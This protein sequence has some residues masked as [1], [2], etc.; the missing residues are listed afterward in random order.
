VLFFSSVN[1]KSFDLDNFV[2][3]WAVDLNPTTEDI[4][5]YRFF[6]QRSNSPEGP[7]DELNTPAPLT[8]VYTFTD[9]QIDRLSKWRRYFYRIR[10][11]DVTDPTV[12][13]ISSPK[14]FLVPIL[15]IQS[16]V[17][18]EIIR[19]EKIILNGIG[20]TP[21]TVGIKCLVFIRRTFG[22]RCPDCWDPVKKKVSRSQCEQCFA[23][24]FKGGYHAPIVV[25][26]NFS[27]PA[28]QV[29]LTPIGETQPDVIKA[30]MTN[31]PPLT[32]GDLI[33]DSNNVRWRVVNQTRTEALRNM[34]RQTLS[35]YHLPPGDIEYLVPFDT[36]L[37]L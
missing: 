7:F 10:A 32:G 35:L 21:S 8:D 33:V 34:V 18:R 4:T 9:T 37:L 24:G 19:T 36:D 25:D 31:Y 28:D 22:Q 6:V 5:K 12:E 14:E 1:V 2:V 3:T 30:W 13:V 20:I 11:I 26:V 23:V 29:E 17:Q 27:P 16:L 15:N